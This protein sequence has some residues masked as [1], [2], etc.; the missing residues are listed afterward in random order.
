MLLLLRYLAIPIIGAFIGWITNVLAIRFIFWPYEPFKI[1]FTKWE[2]LGVIPKR[3]REIAANIGQVVEKELFSVED[4]IAFLEENELKDK[5]YLST[6]TAIRNTVIER[7]PKYVPG[8]VKD[9]LANMLEETLKKEL[10]NML[11]RLSLEMGNELRSQINLREI[12]E[13]RINNFDAREMEALILQVSSRELWYIEIMG[14]IL[15]FTIGLVQ[16]AIAIFV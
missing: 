10:P 5:M 1:P 2:V 9:I 7:L 15:G 16:T 4:F 8:Y 11:D 12:I 3:R 14:G 6:L 13:E